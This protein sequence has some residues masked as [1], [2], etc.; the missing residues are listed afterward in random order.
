MF[1]PGHEGPKSNDV[2]L[3]MSGHVSHVRAQ[4]EPSDGGAEYCVRVHHWI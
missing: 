2:K 3:R 4:A 1:A